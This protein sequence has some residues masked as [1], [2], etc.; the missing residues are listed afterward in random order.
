M[1]SRISRI[2]GVNLVLMIL[3]P[4]MFLLPFVTRG[5]H[6]RNSL[7]PDARFDAPSASSVVELGR[8]A[9]VN[10]ADA[11]SSI[12]KSA[13]NRKPAQ[14]SG[15][16]VP[17]GEA[18]CGTVDSSASSAYICSLPLTVSGD[19]LYAHDNN[20]DGNDY[21]AIY[22]D[23]HRYV[24]QDPNTRKYADAAV[25]ALTRKLKFTLEQGPDQD[26]LYPFQTWL[27]GAPV[28]LIFATAVELADKM[29]PVPDD[30]LECAAQQYFGM[31]DSQSGCGSAGDSCMDDYTV[32]A[33]GFGWVAAYEKQ[34][35][36]AM[37]AQ[38]YVDRAK[39]LIK[40]SFF[41]LAQPKGSVCFFYAN[42]PLQFGVDAHCDGSPNDPRVRIIGSNHGFE[43]PSYGFGLMTSI[44]A[45]IAGLQKA[46]P[47]FSYPW[48]DPIDPANPDSLTARAVANA[49][50]RNAQ[51][52][53]LFDGS[54]FKREIGADCT[55]V[56]LSPSLCPSSVLPIPPLKVNC[57]DSLISAE[58]YKPRQYALNRFYHKQG[59]DQPVSSPAPIEA[60]APVSCRFYLFD[61]YEPKFD[62]DYFNSDPQKRRSVFFGDLRHVFY[63][64][65]GYEFWVDGSDPTPFFQCT[66]SQPNYEWSI[67]AADCSR[68]SGWIWDQT[69]PYSGVNVVFL[70]GSQE[71]GN[72]WANKFRDDLLMAGKGDGYHGFS[73]E[74]PIAFRDGGVHQI[75]IAVRTKGAPDSITTR[76]ISCAYG[77]NLEAG[78]QSVDCDRFDASNNLVDRG[79]IDGWAHDLSQPGVPID[80][81]I[82]EGD[83][84][85]AL[86]SANIDCQFLRGGCSSDKGLIGSQ[87]FIYYLPNK[88]KDGNI[89]ELEI[90]FASTGAPV[91]ASPIRVGCPPSPSSANPSYEGFVDSGSGCELIHGWAWD[92]TRPNDPIDVSL[93]DGNTFIATL[94]ANL[95]RQDLLDAGK[96]DGRHAFVHY[97]PAALADGNVHQIRV[98]I[99]ASGQELGSSPFILSQCLSR[100]RDVV[101]SAVSG[102]QVNITWIGSSGPVDHY[103]VE[104][105]LSINGP[106]TVV[107]PSVATTTFTD[108]SVSSGVAYLYRVRAVNSSNTVFSAY[109]N[110]DLATAIVFT[111]NPLTAGVTIIKAQ[112][113]AE[114]RQAV[115]SVRTLANLGPFNWAEVIQPGVPIRAAHLQ[116]LRSRLDEARSALRFFPQ[117][118]TDN[119]IGPGT[120]IRKAHI[121]D[122]RL[123]IR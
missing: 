73:F 41:S 91:P 15:C 33:A 37:I 51:E 81:I 31:G 75:G 17:P 13:S 36:G 57:D 83:C 48:N 76:S 58:K 123:G 59:L 119:P 8:A 85:L 16:S 20:K 28:A 107:A 43:N 54:A 88:L 32:A 102:T 108:G 55:N 29:I 94:S 71:I 100:P 103:Q 47:N 39:T 72:V 96:G 69:Q 77:R 53:A 118:Y 40:K 21:G 4:S 92:A 14:S 90:R 23:A 46:V 86:L 50:F 18:P 111:D 122:I 82:S 67:E 5:H 115:N 99:A 120:L 79:R 68:I 52:K 70:E 1:E 63:G 97:V 6:A 98:R 93:F 45:A 38:P 9:T 27:A 42:Y 49:L 34:M 2:R 35:R 25:R 104:R 116:E 22:Q 117:S 56:N 112:Q 19:G 78:I 12:I 121:D 7:Q 89:H 84:Q 109:S 95:F 74:V 87:G 11:S 65:F 80:L 44:A 110:V 26:S 114:L 113:L 30:L 10:K 66:S 60:R 24:P 106:F 62:G 101:A 64:I 105:S 3:L 61:Q